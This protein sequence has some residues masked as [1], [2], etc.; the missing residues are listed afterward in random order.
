MATHSSKSSK[1]N[2]LAWRIPWTEKSGG[3]Q[4]MG[5]QKIGQDLATNV[6]IL[7]LLIPGLQLPDSHSSLFMV[8]IRLWVYLIFFCVIDSCS[9]CSPQASVVFLELILE[10][11]AR[12][13][14]YINSWQ[15]PGLSYCFFCHSSAS[16][17]SCSE[18]R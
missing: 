12:S 1:S 14:S 3:L 5:S 17:K 10:D 15:G 7:S 11:G 18:S 4:F 13:L 2:H 8:D 16:I 6:C 9:L